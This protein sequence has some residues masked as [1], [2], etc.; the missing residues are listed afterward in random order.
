[1]TL[2]GAVFGRL[3]VLA[4]GKPPGSYR[5]TAICR[6]ECGTKE[7]KTRLDALTAG[8]TVSCGCYG[9][10]MH[11]THGQTRSGLHSIWRHMI[12]R[13]TDPKDRAYPDYGGRGIS[14]CQRWL[15]FEN[16]VADMLPSRK[17]SLTL[18]RNNNDGNYEPANCRWATRSEQADNRRMAIT[19]TFSGKTQ[20]IARWAEEIGI[21]YQTLWT[22]LQ[23]ERWSVER[24]LTTAPLSA[25]A[26]MKLARDAQ[27]GRC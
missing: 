24:A 4:V 25:D 6:C 3:T 7:F 8:N 18:E 11:R 26:R 9:R 21:N 5:Y 12:N 19:L 20:T 10:E 2:A 13:C 23:V 17:P 1:M 14:V 15:A 22:R 16:F 27:R